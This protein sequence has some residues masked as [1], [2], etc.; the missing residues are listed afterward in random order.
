MK[1]EGA[2]HKMQVNLQ[3][4]VQYQ[5]NLGG[6]TVKLHEYLGK[7]LRLTSLQAIH[8]IHC[9]RKTSKSFSQGYC[10]P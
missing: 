10:F 6:S 1:F 4:P 9:G 5:L 8:C 2:L 7:Q 3:S